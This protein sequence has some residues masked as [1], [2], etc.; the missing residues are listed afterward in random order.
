MGWLVGAGYSPRIADCN[1]RYKRG[2]RSTELYPL[3]VM[4]G[5][6]V[7]PLL[8]YAVCLSAVWVIFVHQAVC[9]CWL[10]PTAPYLLVWRGEILLLPRNL[11]DKSLKILG[12]K[13]LALNH[14]YV[15]PQPNV[16]SEARVSTLD[17]SRSRRQRG[18]SALV[19][20]WSSQEVNELWPGQER[21][22]DDCS[23]YQVDTGLAPPQHPH[24]H[25]LDCAASIKLTQLLHSSDPEL[26]L[27]LL[28]WPISVHTE[29]PW[30]W[31]ISVYV[32][33]VVHYLGAT[34]LMSLKVGCHFS[35]KK[36][37]T[38][39]K[40]HYNLPPVLHILSLWRKRRQWSGHCRYRLFAVNILPAGCPPTQH[41]CSAG[42]HEAVSTNSALHQDARAK[43]L[44]LNFLLE[45]MSVCYV[46]GAKEDVL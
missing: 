22:A 25:N 3:C 8:C 43:L 4:S 14:Y 38:N 10:P 46:D 9:C 11:E 2:R 5:C 17:P 16:Q 30:V 36:T 26:R 20:K 12:R 39:A 37:T 23:Q 44:Q 15:W 45:E 32:W 34:L 13:T 35:G 18:T 1:T 21:G 40:K 29:I 31:T 42:T 7:Q 24:Q 27:L 19:S 33:Q 41:V 28:G 6:C